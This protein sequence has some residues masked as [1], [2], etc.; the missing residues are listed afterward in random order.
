MFGLRGQSTPAEP[1]SWLQPLRG[2]STFAAKRALGLVAVLLVISF[3]TFS[4]LHVAPGDPAQLLLGTRQQSPAV[5]AAVRAEYHLNKPFLT[6]YWIWLEHATRFDFGR[7]IRT[8]DPVWSDIS[9]R[10][11]LSVFLGVYATLIALLVGVP[12]GILAAVRQRRLADRAAVAFGVAGVSTPAFVSGVA[13]LYLFAVLLNW[14]PVLG[15][16]TGFFDRL[17]HLTLPAIALALTVMALVLKLTRAAMIGALE[18]DYVLFA[19]ARG[20]PE[21]S[22]LFTYALRNALVPIVTAAG[23]VLGSVI[24]GA[25]LVEVVFTLPGVGSLLVE[26]I[27]AKDIPTVQGLIVVLA[28]VIIAVNLLTDL[29]YLALDPRIRFGAK[30]A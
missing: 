13:F 17:Y 5:L 15:G 3:A 7:S 6:Q 26:S 12:L 11:G 23:A 30:N 1:P 21:R 8:E 22:V 2:A 29:A 27:D 16:G 24:A 25:V 14:F 9:A 19:R 20:A 28:V 18:Q 10:L 4:L